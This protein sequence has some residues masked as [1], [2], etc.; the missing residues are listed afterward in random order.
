MFK[1]ND[2]YNYLSFNNDIKDEE[3]LKATRKWKIAYNK[4]IENHEPI[5]FKILL[6]GIDKYI[7]K[8]ISLNDFI[9]WSKILYASLKTTN[10]FYKQYDKNLKLLISNWNDLI[11]FSKTIDESNEIEFI[12]TA[13]RFRAS[14][15]DN[16]LCFLSNPCDEEFEFVRAYEKKKEHNSSET[17][18]CIEKLLII[19]SSGEPE[20]YCYIGSMYYAGDKVSQDY[21]KA[22]EYY[23][24]AYEEGSMPALLNLGYIHYYAR[25]GG[26]PDYEEA[27]KCFKTVS[28]ISIDDCAVEA[29]YK[30][31]DMY[32]K[33]LYV[34]QYKLR[35]YQMIEELYRDYIQSNK[36]RLM[37]D[38]AIRMARMNSKD[39]IIPNDHHAFHYYVQAKQLIEKRWDGKWFGDKT[40]L[41]VCDKNLDYLS[42]AILN[43]DNKKLCFDIYELAT[44]INEYGDYYLDDVS[45]NYDTNELYIYL[46]SYHLN[47]IEYLPYTGTKFYMCIALPISEY[48]INCNNDEVY[49][50]SKCIKM[51]IDKNRIYINEVD[52]EESSLQRVLYAD[53][54]GK[55]YIGF[56]NDDED[57]KIYS[58]D[59]YPENDHLKYVFRFFTE[60]YTFIFSANK[61]ANDEYGYDVDID[62]LNISDKLKK[63]L[64]EAINEYEYLVLS[65]DPDR[66]RMD[67]LKILSK[68]LY[69]RLKRELGHEYHVI[70]CEYD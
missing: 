35:A 37:G 36:E 12:K 30:I 54:T 26:E 3:F 28:D 43:D 57:G 19:G 9:I 1:Y 34:T 68:S 44:L 6:K 69:R 48:K 21:F 5:P 61:K 60:F 53:V 33:G 51:T 47:T 38:L 65:D 11:K 56:I 66:E 14:L 45:F 58:N 40:L 31:A 39:G 25:C 50:E 59:K 67:E 55:A 8:E 22:K 16:R 64:H 27:Y 7:I 15:Y 13:K 41:D 20:A 29:K 42:K 32:E 24:L 2:V 18:E 17:L 52:E 4:L 70:Y 46:N 23:L 49:L 62:A 10:K 63:D